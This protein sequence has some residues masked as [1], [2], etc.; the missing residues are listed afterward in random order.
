M[1]CRLPAYSFGPQPGHDTSAS[2]QKTPFPSGDDFGFPSTNRRI[3]FLENVYVCVFV[4]VCVCVWEVLPQ[5][6]LAPNTPLL[7]S[8]S[9]LGLTA[10]LSNGSSNVLVGIPWVLFLPEQLLLLIGKLPQPMPLPRA[11]SGSSGYLPEEGAQDLVT[12]A[13]SCCLGLG[14]T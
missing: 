9:P 6:P 7:T 12:V 1:S 8:Y 13:L 5:A 4:C 14:P 2:F 10:P 11:D 3:E